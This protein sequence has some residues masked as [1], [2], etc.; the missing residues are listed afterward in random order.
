MKKFLIF[1]LIAFFTTTV[2]AE[3][4]YIRSRT[5]HLLLRPKIGSKKVLKLKKGD[6]VELIKRKKVWVF[7]RHGKKQGWLNRMLIS[8]RKPKLRKSIFS[9]KV[10]I[11][12]TA[13]RRASSF[14]SAAASRGLVADQ[15]TMKNLPTANYAALHKIESLVIDEEEA[16][17]FL[18]YEGD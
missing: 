14:T 1:L 13:R 3:R 4:Y 2:F 6:S 18:M 15:E 11:S 8:K 5:A 12:S 9:N 7:L 16:V 10:D 17:E